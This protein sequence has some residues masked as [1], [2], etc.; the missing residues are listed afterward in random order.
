VALDVRQGKVSPEAAT[1]DYGVVFGGE[2]GHTDA[3]GD[4]GE[5]GDADGVAGAGVGAVHD[6]VRLAVDEAATGALRARLAA[7][8]GEPAMFDRGPGYPRLADGATG[9]AVDR[10]TGS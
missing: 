6:E 5:A 1:R 10:V 4:P 2:G 3:G 9:A 7:D 8:R